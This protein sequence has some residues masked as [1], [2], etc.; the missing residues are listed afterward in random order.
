MQLCITPMMTTRQNF[1]TTCGDQGF[2]AE[3]QMC[4]LSKPSVSNFL[5]DVWQ[6]SSE[7]CCISD[8]ES[9]QNTLQSPFQGSFCGV[10][11]DITA[12]TCSVTGQ[13]QHFKL[14]DAGG[15]SLNCIARYHC[16]NHK[17]LFEGNRVILFAATGLV[18][19]KDD[20]WRLYLVKDAFVLNA[21][22]DSTCP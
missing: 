22:E 14:T 7:L 13:H 18:S 5:E 3:T 11:S 12:V 16:C 8:I 6:T 19:E 1:F 17:N 9:V 21:Y 20:M 10:V 2:G 4:I 15:S